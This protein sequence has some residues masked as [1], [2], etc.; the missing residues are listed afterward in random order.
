MT[1]FPNLPLWFHRQISLSVFGGGTHWSGGC[2]GDS[3][4]SRVVL[5]TSVANC[6]LVPGYK[7]TRS[8]LGDEILDIGAEVLILFF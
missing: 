7:I 2:Q 6:S 8:F 5:E 4:L 3:L 1:K